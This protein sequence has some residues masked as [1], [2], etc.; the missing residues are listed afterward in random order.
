LL[1]LLDSR[2]QAA[3]A[4]PVTAKEKLKWAAFLTFCIAFFVAL[5]T[6]PLH[7]PYR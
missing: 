7:P 4:F 3:G 1:A 5:C 2:W 6:L